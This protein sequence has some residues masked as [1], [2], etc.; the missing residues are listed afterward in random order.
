MA[1][2]VG[3]LLATA[4]VPL[5]LSYLLFAGVV[6]PKSWVCHIGFFLLKPGSLPRQQSF[7]IS[8]HPSMRHE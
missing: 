3:V 4:F 6:V 1:L 5:L 2:V 7:D 8:Y